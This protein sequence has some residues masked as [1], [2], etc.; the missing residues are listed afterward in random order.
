[1]HTEKQRIFGVKILGILGI[2]ISIIS[3]I[4]VIRMNLEHQAVFTLRYNIL[5]FFYILGL[6][7]SSVGIILLKEWARVLMIVILAI[8]ITASMIKFINYVISDSLFQMKLLHLLEQFISII[9]LSSV[10]YF[11]SRK[12]IRKQFRINSVRTR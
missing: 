1:M 11:L 12:S 8:K 2:F 6:F 7:A 4:I 10:V 9:I 5:A 3:L